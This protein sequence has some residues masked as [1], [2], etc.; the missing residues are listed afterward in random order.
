MPRLPGRC[1]KWPNGMDMLYDA[2]I[3]SYMRAGLAAQSARAVLDQASPPQTVY[4][5]HNAPSSEAIDGVCD[6]MSGHNFGCRARHAV[7]QLCDSPLVLFVDDDVILGPHVAENL[8]AGHIRHPRSVI[9]VVGRKA[10]EADPHRYTGGTDCHSYAGE[11]AVSVVKG[12]IHLVPRTML[13]LAF[14][15]DLPGEVAGEDDIV[16]NAAVQIETGEP[17]WVAGAIPRGDITDIP[18]KSGCAFRKD[19]WARRN[20]AW[21]YMEALGWNPMLY[22]N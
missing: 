11:F 6:I 22:A 18:V 21:A 12:K 9:G 14:C 8:L 3:L 4:V 5:W 20:R 10:R 19:H 1:A 16:L 2:V 13:S 15:R 7:A 17:S